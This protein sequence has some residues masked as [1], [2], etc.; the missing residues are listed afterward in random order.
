MLYKL[1]QAQSD[2]LFPARQI[3]RLGAGMARMLDLGQYTPPPLRHFGAACA[4]LAGSGLTHSRPDFGFRTVV[5]GNDMVAV[6]EE[7]RFETPFGTLLRFHKDTNI[8]QPRV[9]VVAPMS[10]HFATLLRGTVATLL[11]DHDVYITD[12]RNARDIPLSEGR[13]GFD[14]YV[15]HLIRFMEVLGEG[16]HMI[17]V[18]QPAVAALAATAVMAEMGSRAQPRSLTLMA[19]PIDTRANPTKVNELAKSHPIEWFEK[20]LI[21][22]VPWRY[23]GAFRR[24]YPGFVQLTAFMSM[25][26][27]RH[28]NA[29]LNQFRA[30]VG[31]D[32]LSAE[33]HRKFYDEYNAVMDLPAEFFL[34]TVKRVFQDHDLPLGRLTWHGHAVRPEAIRRTALLTVEGERDD[35][36]AVGQTMAALDLCTGVRISHKRHHLQSGVGHYGVFSGS[37]W[38]REVY[39]KVRAMIE[40]TNRQG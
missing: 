38:A 34:E 33:Q 16:S 2:L 13:F 17:A 6:A 39:P 23:K 26:I 21:A 25:N 14:E 10:G 12:W 18:C 27:D 22:G 30:L 37:R 19:G 28:I 15:D 4:M 20:N 5:I 11:P 36:C 8:V 9:L 29:H 40:V 1:Y 3:A 35:I 24:V 32:V 31:G 7:A